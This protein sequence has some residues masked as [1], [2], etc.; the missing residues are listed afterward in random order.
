MDL[1]V[2]SG[3]TIRVNGQLPSL[4]SPDAPASDAGEAS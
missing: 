1:P 2:V 3:P 4:V